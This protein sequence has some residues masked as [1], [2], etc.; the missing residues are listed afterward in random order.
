MIEELALALEFL[1]E[2]PDAA[3]RVLEQHEAAEVAVFLGTLPDD[4][5]RLVLDRALP[6]FTGRLCVHVEA[7]VAARILLELPVSKMV[8]I[9]RHLD[10]PHVDA[11]LQECP[12]S[13]RNA[14]R[15]LLHY[16]LQCAGAWIVPNTAVVSSEFTAEEILAFLRD[17]T[18]DTFSKYV[19]IVD[20]DGA[21]CGR[22]SYLNLLKAG[23]R[24]QAG[25]LMESP[26]AVITGSTLLAE[27]VKLPCWHEGDVVPVTGHQHQFIGVLRHADLRHGLAGQQRHEQVE[28]PGTD[29]MSG[30]F[31]V[32]GNSLL[33]L[34]NSISNVVEHDLKS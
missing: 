3:V 24:Q 17:A 23:P 20:R 10:T 11:I 25:H 9:L 8:S 7:E 31:D 26:V 1:D 16:P 4:Y 21:P 28:Q 15:L 27:A 33:A 29:P 5:F 32:Y 18:E 13:R 6:A 2:H 12:K 34:F 14:C 19:F 30:I 22:I